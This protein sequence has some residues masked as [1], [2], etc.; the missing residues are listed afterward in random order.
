MEST[1]INIRTSSDLKAQAQEIL[2]A[3]GLDMSTAINMFLRQVVYREA[4]PFEISRP[5][6]DGTVNE[7]GCLAL[8]SYPNSSLRLC[9]APLRFR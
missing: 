1:N 2:A 4:I 7:R 6:K 3:L 9:A 8:C 5:S